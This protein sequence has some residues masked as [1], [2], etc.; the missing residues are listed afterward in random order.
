MLPAQNNTSCRCVGKGKISI[1]TPTR[2]RS[3]N[4]TGENTLVAL[5]IIRRRRSGGDS[6]CLHAERDL[7]VSLWRRPHEGKRLPCEK[8]YLFAQPF[9]PLGPLDS[10]GF[11]AAPCATLFAHPWP[12]PT[13]SFGRLGTR[14]AVGFRA[15]WSARGRTRPGTPK[16]VSGFWRTTPQRIVQFSF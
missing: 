7:Q 10:M 2:Q 1:P 4:E 5:P 11:T 14:C 6:R 16:R 3:Q 9:L 8:H 15:R 13:R 12:A